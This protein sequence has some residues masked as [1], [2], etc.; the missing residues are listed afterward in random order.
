VSPSIADRPA[1]RSDTAPCDC[2]DDVPV[3]A[4]EHHPG[5]LLLSNRVKK[6]ANTV[7]PTAGGVHTVV[8]VLSPQAKLC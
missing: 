4:H 7:Y 3:A 5:K 2:R 1:A 8:R 6:L